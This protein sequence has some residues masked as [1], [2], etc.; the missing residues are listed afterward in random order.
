MKLYRYIYLVLL[1]PFLAC[2]ENDE[3]PSYQLVG[4]AYAT[5]V[6]FS[7]SD[8][9]PP[10]GTDIDIVLSYSNYVEDPIVSITLLEQIGTGDRTEITT[11]NES[12]A[13]IGELV[14]RTISY[15]VPN[16]GSETNVSIFVELRSQ[17]EFPQIE[18]T[19]LEVQ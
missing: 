3:V 14:T 17:K 19:E 8:D 11:L 18:E 1:M 7:V 6:E 16:V 15:T 13:P 10:A 2:E 4:E 9:N 5:Y 12:S